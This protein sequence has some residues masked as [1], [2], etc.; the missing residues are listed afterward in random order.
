MGEGVCASLEWSPSASREP[1]FGW[2]QEV[3]PEAH[4]QPP[5]SSLDPS[6]LKAEGPWAWH[7]G[8]QALVPNFLPSAA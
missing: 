6:S 2:F 8:L 7:L 4:V 3:C 1:D 5:F